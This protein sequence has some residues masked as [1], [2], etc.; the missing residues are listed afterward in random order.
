[1]K[2]TV[3]AANPLVVIPA[4]FKMPLEYMVAAAILMAVFGFRFLGDA[5][6]GVAGAVTMST[7]DMSVLF[8]AMAIKV[9]WALISAYLLTVNMR[10][11]GL[12][13]ISKKQQFG[14]FSR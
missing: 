14:W 3:L 12:L 9:G 11:L 4:I 1:M 6:S 5:I 10:I 2:D 7:K 13:Y 8:V